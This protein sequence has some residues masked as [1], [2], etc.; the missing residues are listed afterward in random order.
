[1]FLFSGDF[2][3]LQNNGLVTCQTKKN[4]LWKTQFWNLVKTKTKLIF[5]ENIC[6]GYQNQCLQTFLVCV[7][8]CVCV[9]M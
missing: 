8:V 9:H 5:S 3:V 7:C 6:L 4:K 2:A 1:M